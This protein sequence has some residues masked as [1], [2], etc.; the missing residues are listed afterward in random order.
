MCQILVTTQVKGLKDAKYFK[1]MVNDCLDQIQ[2]YL[3]NGYSPQDI[4][5]LT[6]FMRTKSMGKTK[7]FKAVETFYYEAKARNVKVAIDNAKIIIGSSDVGE[8]FTGYIA[9][10][11][12]YDFALSKEKVKALMEQTRPESV[13][14]SKGKE[15]GKSK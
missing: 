5:V 10:F 9:S 6:R 1:N 4:L 2:K 14:G 7:W 3:S 12:M 8:P 15:K 13:S 11:Q